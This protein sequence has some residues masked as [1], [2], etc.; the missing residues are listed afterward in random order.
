[1]NGFYSKGIKSYMENLKLRILGDRRKDYLYHMRWCQYS[2]TQN[3]VLG[4]L[5]LF[6]HYFMYKRL[7]A[8]LGYSIGYKSFGYGLII[9]HYGT[10]VVNEGTNAGNYCVL[11]T[12][13][14]I[15]GSGKIIGDNL[16]LGVGAK[17]IGDN[18]SVGANVSIG[19]NS[20]VTNNISSNVLVVDTPARV[21][22][23]NYPS[24]WIRDG[25]GYQ[26]RVQICNSLIEH[27]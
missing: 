27:I 12:S 8:K 23:E 17:I 22:K 1:M 3:N 20:T 7:G 25:I 5:F 19:A 6:Y 15:A 24:W 9:P 2:C 14:C 10:I 18:I 13:T 16:Y 21:I 26:Q 4:K 11:H